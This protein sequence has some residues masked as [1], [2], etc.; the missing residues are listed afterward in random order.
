VIDGRGGSPRESSSFGQH[1]ELDS[2]LR[3][4]WWAAVAAIARRTGDLDV[5]E[6]AV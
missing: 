5:A 1:R 2:A 6:E 4:H 3:E